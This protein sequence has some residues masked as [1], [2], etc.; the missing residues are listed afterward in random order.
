M[1]IGGCY[2]TDVLA[3]ISTDQYFLINSISS[4]SFFP[5]VM[6]AYYKA[7]RTAD[8]RNAARTTMRLLQS[9]I[10]LA[11]AHARLMYRETVLVEDAINAIII[12]ESS[13]QVFSLDYSR[14]KVVNNCVFVQLGL[15]S[16]QYSSA[17]SLS[18]C[19]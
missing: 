13:M 16:L 2:P 17:F 12:I 1:L 3:L 5:S 10:R 18:H 7:Q 9:L 14:V 6:S 19:I 4:H 11:Q 15:C 8:I